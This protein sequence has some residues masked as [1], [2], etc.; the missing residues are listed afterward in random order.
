LTTAGLPAKAA[1]F[2]WEGAAAWTGGCSAGVCEVDAAEGIAVG[3]SSTGRIDE[4]ASFRPIGRRSAT[5]A[6]NT[7]QS[8]KSLLRQSCQAPPVTLIDE[9]WSFQVLSS[10]AVAASKVALFP[11]K[12]MCSYTV[13]AGV[14]AAAG[15][16]TPSARAAVHPFLDM[17]KQGYSH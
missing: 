10:E 3:G 1:A 7:R 15:R 2:T 17:G 11:A 13:I 5:S 12:S 6:S 4:M 8:L 16:A 14:A 9:A